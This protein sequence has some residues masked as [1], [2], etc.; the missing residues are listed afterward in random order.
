MHIVLRPARDD[1]FAF[2]WA[3]YTAE[4]AWMI[5]SL[6]LDV[7]VVSEKF[8]RAWKAD[9][10][11]IIAVDGQEIGW[12][13]QRVQDGTLYLAQIFVDKAVQ[14][15]GIGTTVVNGLLKEAVE[16]AQSV[17]LG[18]IRNNP[19]VRLYK[20]LGFYVTG[21]DEQKLYMRRELNVA[22]PIANLRG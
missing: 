3:L 14:N 11:R 19:A 22:A 7:D 21:E 6:N 16:A 2:C 13:Q 20:R 17:T 12:M 10:T 18:V 1:D 5:H 8:R 9:E 15:R 4:G